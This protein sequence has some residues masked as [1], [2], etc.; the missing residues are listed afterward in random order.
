MTT[1]SR[2][3]SND[4]SEMIWAATTAAKPAA[5]PLTLVCEPL[6][7]P[8][9][10]PPT[11][12]ASNPENSGALDANATPKHRGNATRN[13]TN[14]AVRSRGRVVAD[15]ILVSVMISSKLIDC[16]HQPEA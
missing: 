7:A 14:P 9:R 6:K 16:P 1:A 11:I 3:V 15:N 8:T 12:P 13:T 4:P 2:N 5:G 10:M